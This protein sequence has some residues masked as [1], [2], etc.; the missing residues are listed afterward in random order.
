MN[1]FKLMMVI[2]L[3]FLTSCATFNDGEI[4]DDD[5]QALIVE[6]VAAA[7]AKKVFLHVKAYVET[8]KV[9]LL[10]KTK[11][12]DYKEE[13][14]ELLKR[15]SNISFVATPEESDEHWHVT[16]RLNPDINYGLGIASWLT[17]GLVPYWETDSYNQVEMKVM[18][19]KTK[20]EKK[21][22]DVKKGYTFIAHP[23]FI[24][25]APF[26]ACN[27]RNSRRTLFLEAFAKYAGG[28]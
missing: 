25:V 20:T 23:T 26:T 11:S 6:K 8:D 14:E 12:E 13:I 3:L 21:N 4:Y 24:F 28:N 18:D 19:A 22:V 9:L 27:L 1:L 7:P 16:T 10:D 15:A 17:F 2:P 5:K